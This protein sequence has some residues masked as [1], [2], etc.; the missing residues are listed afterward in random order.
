[1]AP[2][3]QDIE[4]LTDEELDK[5]AD[6]D[7]M[8]ALM[9]KSKRLLL[10]GGLAAARPYL[11]LAS[12]LGNREANVALAKIY[13]DEDNFEEAYDLYALAYGKG[14][15]DVLPDFARLYMKLWDFDTGLEILKQHALL[16]DKGCLKELVRFYTDLKD[17]EEA[18]EWTKKLDETYTEAGAENAE[19]QS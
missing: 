18:A 12:I 15:D 6:A 7:N 14:D 13:E 5:L 17:D 10:S 8:N 11:T 3:K 1:M 9:E 4:K 2:V 19:S 16:G